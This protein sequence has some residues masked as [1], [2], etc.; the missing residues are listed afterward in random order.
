SASERALV[1]PK[2]S[3]PKTKPAAT[4]KPG[5]A[6]RV[7]RAPESR[8]PTIATAMTLAAN[9]TATEL[10]ANRRVNAKVNEKTAV[11]KPKWNTGERLT[12]ASFA[13]SSAYAAVTT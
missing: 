9:R 10:K 6:T 8:S 1:P 2:T 4:S 11:S 12:N 3:K 7:S 5:R 13:T